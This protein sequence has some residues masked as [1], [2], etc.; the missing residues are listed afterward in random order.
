VCMLS[1]AL[2]NWQQRCLGQRVAAP[3]SMHPC[4][5]S[6]VADCPLLLPFPCVSAVLLCRY[7][8]AVDPEVSSK[9][10]AG[11]SAFRQAAEAALAAA[12]LHLTEAAALWHEYRSVVYS[13]RL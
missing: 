2:V 9:S 6:V 3:A 7:L 8:A 11:L 1:L 4:V 10:A 13:L 5:A 12:G